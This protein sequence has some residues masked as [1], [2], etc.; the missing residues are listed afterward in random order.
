MTKSNIFY[1]YIYLDPRKPG[2]YKYGDYIFDHEPFYV[3]KGHSSQSIRH[4]QEIKNNYSTKWTGNLFKQRKIQNILNKGIEPII[5][6]IEENLF[7]VDA[8]N[9][10]IWLIWA[11]GR[12]D[13]NLG[14]LTNL[15]DGGDGTS[16]W[17]HTDEWKLKVSE[18]MRGEKN[19]FFGK[20]HKSETIKKFSITNK[21][22]HNEE[23]KIKIGNSVRGEKNGFFGKKHSEETKLKI[24]ISQ[25]RR[26]TERS[27]N[28]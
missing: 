10:E 23:T 1:T 12:Y 28:A 4:L 16:G 27:S 26:I 9:L 8:F 25:K 21:H 20:K 24:S 13:L 3:G 5:L 7:E 22:P 14:S 19:H 18:V 6:K 15:T 11:I 2:Q 17:V